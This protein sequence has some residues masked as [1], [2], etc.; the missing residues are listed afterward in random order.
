[1]EATWLEQNELKS[2]QWER[3]SKCKGEG[4]GIQIM[5]GLGGHC[6]NYVLG[7]M[8][9]TDNFELLSDII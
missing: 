7:K 2:K 3:R 6:K 4:F 1:M 8:G 9:V 5:L